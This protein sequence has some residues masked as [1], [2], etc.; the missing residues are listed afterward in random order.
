MTSGKPIVRVFS[1]LLTPVLLTVIFLTI[2][3]GPAS[4]PQQGDLEPTLT[5]P[6]P[7]SPGVAMLARVAEAAELRAGPGSTYAVL[8]S[9][10]ADTPI[11]LTARSRIG[12]WVEA[13][14]G[15]ALNRISGWVQTGFVAM[16]GI[17]L[18][19]LAV[20]SV[21]DA[22]LNAITDPDLI[23]LFAAPV[24][25]TVHESMRV[26][27]AQGQMMGNRAEVVVK[28]GD[29]NSASPYYLV[30]LRTGAVELGPYDFLQSAAEFFGPAL[31]ETF[32]T[33]QVGLNTYSLFDPDWADPGRCRAS[34]SPLACEYRLTQPAIAL[35][36][37]GPNDIRALNSDRYREQ[38][39][40]LVDDSLTA[41][42]IPVL[43][44]FSSAEEDPDLQAQAIRFNLILLDVAEQARVPLINLWAAAQVLPNDGIGGD[45]VHMTVGSGRIIFTG[46]QEARFGVSLQNL[47]V[48]TLLDTLRREVIAPVEQG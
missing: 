30:P 21:A 17:P 37:F 44:T 4:A 8:A 23:R 45:G 41:G 6:P 28:V 12:N 1:L 36:M 9:L 7:R 31:P 15:A 33:A 38:M 48:L 20:R 42:V 24:I 5:A 3:T 43:T 22:D 27:Y 26:V 10:P 32:M 46:G 14:T 39:T 13:Q 18:S 25:P 29:S 40:R 16:D 34:E 19:T 35:V 11:T 2:L 47:L